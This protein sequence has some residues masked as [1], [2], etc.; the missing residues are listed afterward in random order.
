MESK[1]EKWISEHEILDPTEMGKQ[2]V[3]FVG[4][5]ANCGELYYEYYDGTVCSD[6]CGKAF[7]QSLIRICY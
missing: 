2:N 7:V 5:C 1:Y 6:Q 3:L 4:K